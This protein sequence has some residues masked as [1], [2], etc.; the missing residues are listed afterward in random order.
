MRRRTRQRTPASGNP[1]PDRSGPNKVRND[2]LVYHR[3]VQQTA[4]F[5]TG[6][7]SRAG[8][9]RS[10]KRVIWRIGNFGQYNEYLL[11]WTGLWLNGWFTIPTESLTGPSDFIW[12]SDRKFSSKNVRFTNLELYVNSVLSWTYLFWCC[13]DRK[14]LLCIEFYWNWLY[15]DVESVPKQDSSRFEGNIFH[16]FNIHRL[17]WLIR[18]FSE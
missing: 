1:K 13:R 16:T 14:V 7:F 6:L 10:H 5:I 18:C 15:S 11:C 9:L 4:W 3:L 2:T 12:Y 17:Y 8:T